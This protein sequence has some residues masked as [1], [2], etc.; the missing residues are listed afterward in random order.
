VTERFRRIDENTLGWDVV[1]DD[2]GAYT[3]PFEVKRRFQRSTIPFMQSPWNCSVRD[4]LY[5]TETLLE[6]A[7]PAR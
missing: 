6:T 1:I 4:N 3:Q 5:F 2:P 7:A